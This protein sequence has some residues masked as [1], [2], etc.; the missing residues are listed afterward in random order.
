MARDRSVERY[1]RTR[2]GGGRGA[3]ARA[4]DYIALRLILFAGAFLF[5]RSRFGS[6]WIVAALSALTLGLCMILMRLYRE[7]AFERFSRRE[8]ERLRRAALADRLMLAPRRYLETLCHTLLRPCETAALLVCALP[9]DA[10]ALLETV[11]KEPLRPLC[12]FSTAGFARSAEEL[13]PRLSG[14]RLC[15]QDALIEAAER[16]GVCAADADV[17]DRI[18]AILAAAKQ[19]RRRSFSFNFPRS[20]VRRYL[21]AAL[22]LFGCSFLTRYALYY[23]MFA[24]LCVSIAG[25]CAALSARKKPAAPDA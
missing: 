11:R 7:I 5:Y 25:V 8:H 16:I 15:G 6:L 21:L 18:R 14:V 24:G 3:F 23:R 4:L 20:A 13:A 17:D 12:V 22:V 19:R 9:A 10:D 2:Y 1:Y